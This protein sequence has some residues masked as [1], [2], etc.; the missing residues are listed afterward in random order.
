MAITLQAM[1]KQMKT[2][3]PFSCT[4]VTYDRKR[5]TGGRVDE[6][7][8]ARLYDPKMEQQST[9][10]ATEVERLRE[11][12]RSAGSR[13]PNHG[14]HFTRNIQLLIDGHPTSEIRKIHPPL[15][16]LF[17]NEIVLG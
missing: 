11:E 12:L 10:A 2:G 3:D 15:V 1:L 6:Y 4:V 17:N 9:R 13:R 7:G 16:V 14:L 8:E 5:K